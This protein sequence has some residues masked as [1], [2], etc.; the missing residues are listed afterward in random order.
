MA[1]LVSFLTLLSRTTLW[2]LSCTL[3][4]AFCG[5]FYFYSI[6]PGTLS[7]IQIEAAQDKELRFYVL[8]DS[9]TGHRFQWKVAEAMEALCARDGAPD[10]LILLGDNI[11]QSGVQHSRDLLWDR[12]LFQPYGGYCLS[13]VPIFPVLGNHDYKGH[14][15]A[16]IEL[17][18]L[19]RRWRMPA[20]FYRA[21]FGNIL[22]VIAMDTNRIGLCGSSRNCLLDFIRTSLEDKEQF[23]WNIAIGHHPIAHSSVKYRGRGFVAANIRRGIL[24]RVLCNSVDGYLSGHV[25]Q[26][27][28]WRDPTCSADYFISGGGGAKTYQMVKNLPESRFGASKYGFLAM[29]VHKDYMKYAFYDERGD[30]LYQFDRLHSKARLS[31]R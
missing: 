23:R 17:S 31:V 4:L 30:I 26:L 28:H 25:H 13:Q 21:R 8:G 20:P 29:N 2:S 7:T 3:L 18:S 14:P 6:G 12:N 10:G 16:Q 1:R 9:G 11:Y 19:N 22:Q 5:G 15:D 24:H 27:E